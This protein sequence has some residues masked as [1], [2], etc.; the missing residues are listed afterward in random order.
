M[1]RKSSFLLLA[2]IIL[3]MVAATLIEKQFGTATMI[4]GSWWFASL[5]ALLAVCALCYCLRRKL[6]KRPATFLLHIS[7]VLILIG[8]LIT[9]I[10]GQQGSVHLR[11][12]QPSA[13]YIT[14][15]HHVHQLPFLMTLQDFEVE[16]YPGTQSPMDYVSRIE[17]GSHPSNPSNPQ[18]LKTSKPQNLTTSS[19]QNL[20]TSKPQNLLIS[21]NHI[22]QHQHYRFY[23]SGYDPDMQGTYL[24]MSHDPW[25]IGVTYTGYALLFLSMLL[26]LVLPNE[27]LRKA[28][29]KQQTVVLLA[30]LSL[31]PTSPAWAAPK[32]LPAEQAAEFCNLHAYYNGRIC[33][34]QTVAKD[35]TVKLYGK[36]SYEGMNFE[37]VFCGFVFYPTT[38]LEEP[39]IK[40]KG[41]AI[42]ALGIDGKY[43]AY[44]DFFDGNRY[45]LEEH[46]YNNQRA[47]L[48]A[49]EKANILK[50]LWA[51]ELLKLYP[52]EGQWLSQGDDLPM[53]MPQEEYFFIKK[54]MDYVGELV[55]TQQYDKLSETIGKIRTY[56][57]KQCSI[58]DEDGHI[59]GSSLPSDKVFQAEKLYNTSDYTKPLAMLFATLGIVLFVVFVTTKPKKWLIILCNL[60]LG[61]TL[62]YMLFLLCLRAYVSGHLPLSNGYETMQ[63]MA[64]CVLA[65]T[66]IMQLPNAIAKHSPRSAHFSLFA[67]SFLTHPFGFLLTGLTLLV[68]MMGEANPQITLLMPV[69]QSPLLSLHVCVIMVAYSLLAFTFLNGIAYFILS[70]RSTEKSKNRIIATSNPSTSSN[71]STPSNSS[72]SS[73]PSNLQPLTTTSRLLLYPALFC[74]AAG[75]F[76]GAIWANVSWGRYWGWDPKEVWALITL[77]VYSFAMHTESLPFLRRPRV[78]HL[79]MILAFL[80]VLMTYFGVNFLLGGMHSYANS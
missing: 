73:N 57:Q 52:Y 36:T 62:L 51:G 76:I 34:L 21:M 47:I 40:V 50:M 5:W 72:N 2:I 35:F 6:Q 60:L 42:Q 1:L 65:I 68:S 55:V 59:I 19:P 22:G 14:D 9:H 79:F 10:W 41:E 64:F 74:M 70:Y 80:S 49:D 26:L 8:A 32:T 39:M 43:A 78:F 67:S 38:W 24:S 44:K 61:M 54:S 37:Q 29:K 20:I 75:I 7:F 58:L 71:S 23:Q 63:F 16:Y 17:C 13:E 4:Y 31:C 56:Q 53:E 66:L 30:I 45:K 12:G 11:I 48:E 28:L 25:G 18:N 15:D 3:V 27:G 69:L 33:P 77:L 46:L